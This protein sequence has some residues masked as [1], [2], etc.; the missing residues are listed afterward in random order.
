MNQYK[1]ELTAYIRKVLRVE[2]LEQESDA[3]MMTALEDKTW[4][5]QIARD[6]DAMRSEATRLKDE[7]YGEG[8][9][10]TTL[11]ES[12]G[13]KRIIIV[14]DG[15]TYLIEHSFLAVNVNRID[16]VIE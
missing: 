2:W 8:H 6:L 4:N 5:E 13:V 11:M 14:V 16:V 12:E 7:L 3:K 15:N 10:L 9:D 1:T